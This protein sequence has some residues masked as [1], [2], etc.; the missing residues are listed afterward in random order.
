S[1]K[2][3]ENAPKTANISPEWRATGAI[4]RKRHSFRHIPPNRLVVAGV[5]L[6]RNVADIL[7][8]RAAADRRV[9]IETHSEHILLR[10]RTLIAKGKISPDN[11]ALYFVERR[12]LKSFVRKVEIDGDGHIAPEE[13]PKDF[14]SDKFTGAMELATAQRNAKQSND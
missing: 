11:V 6:Q 9:A 2:Q 1:A 10:V 7:V 13:W 8:D 3:A 5:Q 12:G 4:V 14:F